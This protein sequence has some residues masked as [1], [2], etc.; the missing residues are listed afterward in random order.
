MVVKVA[1]LIAMVIGGHQ[2]TDGEP[3]RIPRLQGPVASL[4]LERVGS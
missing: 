4:H 3:E 1:S 2:F